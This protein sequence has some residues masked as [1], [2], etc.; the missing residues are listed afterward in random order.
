M[1]PKRRDPDEPYLAPQVTL[2]GR[3]ALI[4]THLDK[5]AGM[6]GPAQA[7]AWIINEWISGEGRQRLKE[8]YGI[9]VA[10]YEP[11]VVK[12]VSIESR[13]RHKPKA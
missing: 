6:G 8:G 11:E 5:V 1:C 13:Q 9:D 10:A 7:A 12:V 2:R 4:V 3:N